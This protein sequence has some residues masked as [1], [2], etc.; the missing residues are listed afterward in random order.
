MLLAF[1]AAYQTV[2]AAETS[3]VTVSHNEIRLNAGQSTYLFTKRSST[4]ALDSV[5]VSGKK[6]ALPMS[7]AD[8]FWLGG[9]EALTFT[10]V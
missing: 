3:N 2:A 7:R 8:S 6:T 4:W 5:W 10:V 9:G 1:P